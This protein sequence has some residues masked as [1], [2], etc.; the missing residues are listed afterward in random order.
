MPLKHL[1]RRREIAAGLEGVGF[2]LLP[3]SPHAES[4][5]SSRAQGCL[6]PATSCLKGAANLLF[7]FLT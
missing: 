4:V 2:P 6:G 7:S 3:E 1:F 5:D